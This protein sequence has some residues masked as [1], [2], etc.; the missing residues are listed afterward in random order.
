M[1]FDAG[2]VAKHIYSWL[3]SYSEKSGVGSYVVGVSGGIDSAVTASLCALTGRPTFLVNMPI[4][5]AESEV[6]RSDEL[7]KSLT[8]KHSNVSSTSVS[9][10]EVY[11]ALRASLP[12]ISD[13][14]NGLAMAN[15]RARLRMTTLYALAAERGALVVG[16]GNKIE[17]FG[18]GFYTKYG[19]GGVDLSPI[20]DLV[21]SEVFSVGAHLEVPQSI[22]D[23]SP[24][25]G[26]WGDDR[27]DEDQ[28]GASYPELEI[29]MKKD[30]GFKA[31]NGSPDDL[32]GR[33][34]EVYAV[35]SRLNRI[36]QH[37]MQPIPVCKI[38]R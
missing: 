21:K 32:T 7:I 35:Y 34:A 31:G 2:A 38:P 26:L 23:A 18:V 24:T 20:A 27:N 33:E 12:A 19:D 3:D 11:E 1:A 22:L 14:S 10:T 6:S 36:N 29:A 4:H 8:L 25:D 5:Q 17:D 15:T 37:K 9:L 28:I 16:T 30:E 13:K